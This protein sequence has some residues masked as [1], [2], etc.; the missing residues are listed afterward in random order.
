MR[1]LPQRKAGVL[2]GASH[3][4]TSSSSSG[5]SNASG[6]YSLTFDTSSYTTETKTVSTGRVTRT[7]KYRFYWNHVYVQ[8]P[9]SYKYQSLNV[10]V[11]VEIDGKAVDA[12]NAPVMF[13][14]NV[15][16]YTSSS[17]WGATAQ[18]AGM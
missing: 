13:A 6:A 2:T 17:S 7:V 9:V 18:G 15:G 14:I 1:Y 5:A 8:H 12:T 3:S 11:P 4:C 10:S 16:G